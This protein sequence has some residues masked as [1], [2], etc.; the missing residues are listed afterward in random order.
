MRVFIEFRSDPAAFAW[1]I[2]LLNDRDV[3]EN[4]LSNDVLDEV[5]S[6]A[7]ACEG[8]E[9]RKEM[10]RWLGEV[11]CVDGPPVNYQVLERVIIKELNKSARDM[12]KSAAVVAQVVAKWEAAVERAH[13]AT[14]N[15]TTAAGMSARLMTLHPVGRP[16]PN[17]GVDPLF[18]QSMR[19]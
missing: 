17:L 11:E 16:V 3:R 2:R 12:G 6:I 5:V 4:V 10:L 19:L 14:R 7:L 18:F 1:M 8:K 9:N 13:R 15:G